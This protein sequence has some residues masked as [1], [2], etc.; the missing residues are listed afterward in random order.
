MKEKF[1]PLHPERL[2]T[3]RLLAV[4]YRTAEQPDKALPLLE[5]IVRQYKTAFGRDN[6]TTL[7]CIDELLG[8]YVDLGSCDKA[9]AVLA[10]ILPGGESR[11]AVVDQRQAAREKR[12]GELIQR[13]K[14]AAEKYRQELAAKKADHPDTLAARQAFAVALRSQGQRSGAAYHLKAV[15]EARQ[16]LMSADH[17]DIQ[18]C[19]LELGMTRL[20]QKKFAEA[21]PLLLQAYSGF[22]Q[23]E[24]KNPEVVSRATQTL[25]NLVKLYEVWDKKDK[26]AEWRKKLE[27][28][29]K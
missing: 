28:Q 22:K 4:T 24:D 26:A 17:P 15:L 23:N 27:E 13:V 21:E 1:G 12:G 2:N 8:C 7:F 5:L 20:Q 11:P 19:W 25:Q 3:T 10:S 6:P 14:P 16:E 29:T 9:A 18:C